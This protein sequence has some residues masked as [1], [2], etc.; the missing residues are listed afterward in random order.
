MTYKRNVNI[1]YY[2]Y[3]DFEFQLRRFSSRVYLMNY[4]Y[5]FFK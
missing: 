5:R 2:I 4:L 3:R 1:K